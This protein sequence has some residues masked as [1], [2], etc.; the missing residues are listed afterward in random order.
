MD[1][2]LI[3]GG[4]PLDGEL[5][6]SG[7]KNAALPILAATILSEPPV[8]VGNIPHLHDITTTLELLGQ[9][10][11]GL[12]VDEKM[13]IEVDSSTIDKYE[14]PYELVKTMRASILVLGP[15]L[16]RFG[17]AH[18]SLPG[19]C[20][21]GTRPVDI[22]I[23]ALIKLGADIQVE[24]GYIHAKCKRL[25]GCRLVLDKITV[26][27]T[28]NILMAA[29]LAEGTT[30]IENAAKEPEVSDL[31]HF[32][33]KMGA[34]ITGIGTDILTVEG[35][36]KLG[37]PNL[38]YNILPDRIET[39]TYLVAGAISRGRVRLKNTDPTTLDAVLDKLKEA[40]AEITTGDNWIELNMHG[41]RP[42]AV[43][44]RTAPYPA[45]PTDMQAQFTALNAVAEGVGL[46]TETVFEN[47]FMHV[48]E[49]QRMGAQIKIESNT[50]IITGIERLTGA[51]VMATDLRASASLVLAAL[52]ADGNTLVDRIYHIDRGYD[53]IE[54]K[55]T[56]LGASIRRVP[57]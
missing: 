12:M 18:V 31:A 52:V 8:S 17:E 2:L 42:K 35:V 20:A 23:D 39:G 47:R 13:N 28:E 46:I 51:P 5:R 7:A 9:M 1:K 30:I 21:I 34:K 56:Q 41:K 29:T 3:S 19:G 22:H 32:L 27:G 15:L 40:G 14:A 54:E 50:A 11:V 43:S 57:N 16:A 45:F 10:G 25:K 26:T 33:N 49:M 44:V 38:H 36:D 24:A 6:I 53:H 55:L 4:E 37:V 48:Q